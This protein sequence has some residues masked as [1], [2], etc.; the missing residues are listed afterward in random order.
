MTSSHRGQVLSLYKQILR[1]SKLWKSNTGQH[2]DTKVERYYIKHECQRLFRRNKSETSNEKV[3]EYIKEAE[4]RI[5]LAQHYGI[6]YPRLMNVPHNV[7]SPNKASQFKRDQ[8]I[9]QQATP[10]YLKSYE[11]NRKSSG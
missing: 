8:R 1:I 10:I 11:N 4:T 7:L 5:A 2:E 3:H 9:L 6:P